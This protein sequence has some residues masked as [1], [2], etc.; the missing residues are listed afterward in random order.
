MASTG[1]TKTIEGPEYGQSLSLSGIPIK[2]SCKATETGPSLCG[3]DEG[4]KEFLCNR[5]SNG[6]SDLVP[7]G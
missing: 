2:V 1:T 7:K 3:I 5:V 4:V 6:G